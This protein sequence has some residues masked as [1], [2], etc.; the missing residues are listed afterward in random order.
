MNEAVGQV[1]AP[2]AMRTLGLSWPLMVFLLALLGVSAVL[3]ISRGLGDPDTYW[4]ITAGNWIIANGIV[5]LGDPFSHSMPN[6][7]WT[8]QE[9]LSEI[10]F[11]TAY[12]SGGCRNGTSPGSRCV[13]F[14]QGHP[15]W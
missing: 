11:A 1:S 2:S 6:A 15:A 5:P 3:P 13:G 9:W 8:T 7:A 10:V 14:W 12:N 4:H